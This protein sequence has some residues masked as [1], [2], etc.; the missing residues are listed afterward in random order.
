MNALQAIHNQNRNLYAP[1]VNTN[2]TNNKP[3]NNFCLDLII[4]LKQIEREKGI[5]LVIVKKSDSFDTLYI[6]N[7]GFRSKICNIDSNVSITEVK[8][9]IYAKIS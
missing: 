2:E 4:A 9:M 5:H 3:L 7:S 8:S 1:I 6:V